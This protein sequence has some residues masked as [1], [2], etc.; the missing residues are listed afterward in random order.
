MKVAGV[1]KMSAFERDINIY[2]DVISVSSSD[3]QQAKGFYML[4][5]LDESEAETKAVN[6]MK[7]ER[8]CMW[9]R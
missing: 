8:L 9:R 1:K 7:K 6:Y 2:S 3:I 5:G 4:T